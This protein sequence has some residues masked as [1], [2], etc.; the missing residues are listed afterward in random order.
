VT[1]LTSEFSFFIAVLQYCG[2]QI[3]CGFMVEGSLAGGFSANSTADDADF[4]D[5]GTDWTQGT[6]PPSLR[7]G[8]LSERFGCF[9]MFGGTL[10]DCG[11]RISDCEL[12]FCY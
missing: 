2:L 4:T 6:D 11:S 10:V 3:S 1:L 5:N 12:V 9:L 7:F 8:G